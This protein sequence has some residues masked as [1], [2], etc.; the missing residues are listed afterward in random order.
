VRERNVE[1]VRQSFEAF[2]RLDLDGFTQHWRP[3]VVW[4]VTH[5]EGWPGDRTT[6]TGTADVLKGFADY[7]ASARG[8]EV[9]D[10][11]VTPIGDTH[12]LG[13]HLERRER[14][15][16]IEIGVIYELDDGQVTHARVFTG[17]DKARQAA[18]AV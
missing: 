6:Y 5:L 10:L 3:D 18:A 4:D 13:L 9:G 17:H 14:T 11:E 16:T 7:L 2:Q 15:T 8:L 12:V 1:V